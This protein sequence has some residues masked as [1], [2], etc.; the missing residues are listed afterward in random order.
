MLS[1][2][3]VA[4]G[5]VYVKDNAGTLHAIS[6]DGGKKKWAR[7]GAVTGVYGPTVAG[8]RVYYTTDLAIQALEATSG[9]PVWSFTSA[10]AEFLTTPA[11]ASGL[12][13]AGSSNDSLYAIQA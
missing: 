11:V 8:G 13:F 12:V 9:A 3:A 1:D 7:N 10:D 5:M 6:A 2:L 4:S